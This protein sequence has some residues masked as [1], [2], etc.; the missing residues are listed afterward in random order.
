MEKHSEELLEISRSIH[1]NPETAFSEH[2]SAALL[3]DFLAARGFAVERGAAGLETAFVARYGDGPLAV[4]LCAEYDALPGMGH[5]CGHNVIA[6]ASTGAGL[7]LREVADRLGLTVM[8]VGTPAEEDG[9]G[10]LIMLERGVFD[11]VS[12]AMMVHPAPEENCAPRSLAIADLQ[13]RYTG[14]ATHPALSP[15]L[16]VNAADALTVAQV[17]IGLA[18]QHFE[19][20]Q[21]VHGIVTRGGD[22]PNVVADDTAARYYLRAG[23]LSS[24][25]RLESRVR[26][27]FEAGA[28]ATGCGHEVTEVSPAYAELR[29]DPWL[30]AAYRDAARELG[31]PLVSPEAEAAMATGSTDMGNV[32]RVVPSLHPTIAIDGG[33]AVNHQPEFAA[34]CVSPSADRA[35]LDGALALAWTAAQAASDE[36]QRDR[37]LALHAAR[38]AGTPPDAR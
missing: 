8:V 35:V 30:V 5:A 31:R 33:G 38:R 6:A 24:L 28:V 18:R 20:R 27:C 37:L 1:A 7:A 21:M 34:A 16:G 12:V 26:S 17:A 22:S 14:R 9:G 19:E 3:A 29:H 10:K 11:E 23:D 2:R 32:S 15:E 36:A 25:H 13:V 4:A